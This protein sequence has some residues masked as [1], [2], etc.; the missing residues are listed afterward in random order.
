MIVYDELELSRKEMTVC[1]VFA[2]IYRE[3]HGKPKSE[4]PVLRLR[5][6]TR[7]FTYVCEMRTVNLKTFKAELKTI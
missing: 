7:N 5:L 3:N 4:K 2:W 6:E 1:R